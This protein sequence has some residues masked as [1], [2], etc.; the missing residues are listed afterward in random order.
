MEALF[1][2]STHWKGLVHS[3][4]TIAVSLI[5]SLNTLD[6][7]GCPCGCSTAAMHRDTL[8]CA[9]GNDHIMKYVCEC[10][11][12]CQVLGTKGISAANR[13][14]YKWTKCNGTRSSDLLLV[15]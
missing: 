4:S 14:G 5:V 15:C 3:D 13:T 9:V 6:V 8:N 1:D 12:D 2:D 11:V 10:G 7:T